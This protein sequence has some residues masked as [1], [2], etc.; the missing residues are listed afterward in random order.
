MLPFFVVGRDTETLFNIFS[1][2]DELP[3]ENREKVF[4]IEAIKYDA[5]DCSKEKP[6][7]SITLILSP[8]KYG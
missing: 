8:V 2:K 7:G 1:L 6:L 4:L 5:E 3:H